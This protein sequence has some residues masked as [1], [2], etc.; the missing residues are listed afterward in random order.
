MRSSSRVDGRG[1]AGR[2]R[3]RPTE[4]QALAAVNVT[5]MVNVAPW[6][7]VSEALDIATPGT[8][9]D[10]LAVGRDGLGHRGGRERH[11][12]RRAGRVTG[13]RHRGTVRVHRGDRDRERVRVV[14]REVQVRTGDARVER[15]GRGRDAGGE[16]GGEVAVAVPVPPPPTVHAANAAVAASTP[17]VPMTSG[18]DGDGARR[19][20][21]GSGLVTGAWSIDLPLGLWTAPVRPRR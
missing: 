20:A 9:N 21:C 5:G 14:D 8:V 12:G 11:A 10:E 16:V 13:V 2:L 17:A 7:P 1:R 4:D 15:G 6:Q 19:R 18:D 3:S